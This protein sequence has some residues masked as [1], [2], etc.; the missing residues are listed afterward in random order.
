MHERDTLDD[1]LARCLS[2]D[3]PFLLDASVSALENCFPMIPA[4]CGHH[5]VLLG[6]ERPYRESLPDGARAET[7]TNSPGTR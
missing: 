7:T 2:S 4:G 1:A 5:E 3:G 6:K